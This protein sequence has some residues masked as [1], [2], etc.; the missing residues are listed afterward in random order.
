MKRRFR[1]DQPR[2]RGARAGR[3]SSSRT[4]EVPGVEVLSVFD[5]LGCLQDH[6]QVPEAGIV[7]QVS[8]RFEPHLPRADPRVAVD[9]AAPLATTIVQMPDAQALAAPR[10]GSS[11]SIV[12]SYSSSVP[13]E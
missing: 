12:S 8:K 10:T 5:S 1:T 9:A 2:F 6:R 13:S 7:D 11:R 4:L 3:T